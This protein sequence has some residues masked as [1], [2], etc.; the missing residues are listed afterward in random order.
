MAKMKIYTSKFFV[1]Q[2]IINIRNWILLLKLHTVK[3]A[4][5]FTLCK[6]FFFD[7][8]W[9]SSCHHSSFMSALLQTYFPP[10]WRNIFSSKPLKQMASFTPTSRMD[11]DGRLL[12]S[13]QSRKRICRRGNTVCSFLKNLIMEINLLLLGG[14]DLTYSSRIR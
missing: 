5:L 3:T 8:P 11:L 12:P 4:S 7:E 9:C 2:H 6:L 10:L 13:R 14:S 1:N